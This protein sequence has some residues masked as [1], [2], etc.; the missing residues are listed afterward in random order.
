MITDRKGFFWWPVVESSIWETQRIFWIRFSENWFEDQF[1]YTTSL[2]LLTQRYQITSFCMFLKNMTIGC[3]LRNEMS[4]CWIYW[5]LGKLM[6]S[7]Q[8]LFTLWMILSWKNIVKLM[9]KVK[10]S[11]HKFS[12]RLWMMFSLKNF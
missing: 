4:F 5:K 9:M 8:L 1:K 2:I 7:P 3:V 12:L 10:W 11:F 6:D